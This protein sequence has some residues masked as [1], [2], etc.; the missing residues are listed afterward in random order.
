MRLQGL[1]KRRV[2]E[3]RERMRRNAI[4]WRVNRVRNPELA[5]ICLESAVWW[6]GNGES[7]RRDLEVLL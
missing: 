1:L 6:R 5:K 2:L 3:S 4:S 7:W